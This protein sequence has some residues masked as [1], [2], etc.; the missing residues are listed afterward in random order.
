MLFATHYLEEADQYADRIVLIS[1]GRI[2][3]DGT[4]S[5]IKALAAGRTVRATLP[6]ADT[7]RASPRL[8][9]VDGVEVRGEHRASCT[10]RTAT[11]SP[12]TC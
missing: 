8:G 1:H 2:V 7:D 11:P 6:D 4:G 12:A 10:P 5:E 9:G 3:A